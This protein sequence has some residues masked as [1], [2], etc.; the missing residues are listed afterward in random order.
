M[1][2]YPLN[3]RQKDNEEW[4]EFS[5][6]LSPYLGEKETCWLIN[7]MR[8]R[9]ECGNHFTEH[10][11]DD[12]KWAIEKLLDALRH[13]ED[14]LRSANES[15][16]RLSDE[17]ERWKDASGLECRGDPDGVTPEAARKYWD[18]VEA[19]I[20]GIGSIVDVEKEMRN[21]NQRKDRKI[22]K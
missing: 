7:R 19:E 18:E 9:E 2:K 14:A 5:G 6:R 16:V 21:E 20:Y 10:L 15:V 13:R 17:I 4:N 3:P 22:T 8:D 11:V 1:I 12:T